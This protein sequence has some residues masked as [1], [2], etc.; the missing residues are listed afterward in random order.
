MAVESGE[1]TDQGVWESGFDFGFYSVGT[2]VGCSCDSC[3]GH[4]ACQTNASGCAC[5]SNADLLFTLEERAAQ[6]LSTVLISRLQCMPGGGRRGVAGVGGH[7]SALD[8]AAGS[9]VRV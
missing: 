5:D 6:P 7:G 4:D 9:S 2:A 3:F 8:L 1:H